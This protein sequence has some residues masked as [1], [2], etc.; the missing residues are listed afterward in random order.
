M[1]C[2]GNQY[3]YKFQY[4]K[5]LLVVFVASL[6]RIS[7]VSGRYSNVV[8]AYIF[9]SRAR[10]DFREDSDWDV[11]V[12]INQEFNANSFLEFLEDLTEILS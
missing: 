6:N 7:E 1:D 4:W 10:E 5:L 9:G 12:L 8:P 3:L 2:F 11:G